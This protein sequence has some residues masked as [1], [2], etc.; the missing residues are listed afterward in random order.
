MSS[1]IKFPSK[2]CTNNVTNCDQTIQCD[3]CNSWVHIEYN[4]LNYI[5][6]K[7]F[8]NSND[9][10]CFISSCCKKLQK[11]KTL[12]SMIVTTNLKKLMTKT[13]LYY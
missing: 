2:I 3:L 8:H 5:D 9:P 11:V 12:I 7:F 10:W 4:D 13:A 1:A 6:Y